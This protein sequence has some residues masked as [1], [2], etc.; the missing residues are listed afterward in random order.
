LRLTSESRRLALSTRKGTS[1]DEGAWTVGM[2]G[3]VGEEVA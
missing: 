3:G 1:G 2:C